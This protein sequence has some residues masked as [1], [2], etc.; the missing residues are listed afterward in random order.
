MALLCSRSF[1]QSN[2]KVVLLSEESRTLSTPHVK[3]SR[4][5]HHSKGSLNQLRLIDKSML[6]DTKLTA[7]QLGSHSSDSAQQLS[8]EGFEV[9]A[10]VHSI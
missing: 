10:D 7:S 6:F 9:P 1:L 4:R 5:E 8:S 2:S 3:T